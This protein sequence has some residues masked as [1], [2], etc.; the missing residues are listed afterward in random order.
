MRKIAIIFGTRPEAIKLA[1]VVKAF[2][3]KAWAECAVCV[4]GQ[5]RQMLDQVLEVFD[6]RPQHD[7]D[8]MEPDQTLAQADGA[9]GIGS[10]QIFSTYPAKPNSRPR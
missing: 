2:E 6:I 10:R 3:G 9:V 4:T 7:L 1:P 5:H 8:V